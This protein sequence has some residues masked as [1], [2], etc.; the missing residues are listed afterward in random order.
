MPRDYAK[1]YALRKIRR[2]I[3]KIT[4]ADGTTFNI[5]KSCNH[6][7]R[8][9]TADTTCFCCLEVHINV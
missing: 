4:V 5:C 7:I 6:W 8:P 2:S 9:I 3:R 1:E